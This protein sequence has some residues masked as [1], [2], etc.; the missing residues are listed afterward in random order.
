MRLL[1]VMTDRAT[2]TDVAN[3]V[4][5]GRPT[6]WLAVIAGAELAVAF[7][8]FHVLVLLRSVT[9]GDDDERHG[10]RG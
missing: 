5:G 2:S 1:V 7:L 3:R 4:L 6:W 9:P 8:I 10:R